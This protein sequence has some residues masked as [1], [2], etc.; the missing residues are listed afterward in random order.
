MSRD[1]FYD[2]QK[3]YLEL[4]KP[5]ERAAVFYA[6]N[7]SSFSGTTL[8]GGMSPGCPRFTESSIN[9]LRDFKSTNL[10]VEY[11]DYKDAL[12]KHSDKF[13]YLDPP[14]ANGGKLYGNRGD[15]HEGFDHGHLAKIL[16][17]R[18]GW[19]MS[20]NDCEMIRD[21]YEGCKFDV[22]QWTYGMNG[23]KSSNEVLIRG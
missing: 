8:S 6:L 15:M 1:N 18:D 20:Y 12:N 16:R 13:L 19:L 22:P 21:L 3:N 2:L 14:Y 5:L 23:D 11:A 7:R 17:K 10:R 4:E 9:R